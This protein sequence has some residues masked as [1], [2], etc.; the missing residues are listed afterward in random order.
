MPGIGPLQS[1]APLVNLADCFPDLQELKRDFDVIYFLDLCTGIEAA[2]LYD[3]VYAVRS[4]R[5]PGAD[6]LIDPLVQEG[7]IKLLVASSADPWETTKQIFAR[8]RIM[9]LEAKLRRRAWLDHDDMDLAMIAQTAASGLAMELALEEDFDCNL[10]LSPRQ[11]PVY[12]TLEPIERDEKVIADIEDQLADK[13]KKVRDSLMAVRR[14]TAYHALERIPLPPIAFEALR[15]ANTF[16]ELAARIIDLRK[17]YAR[18][19]RKLRQLREVMADRDE[20]VTNRLRWFHAIRADIVRTQDY[21][22]PESAPTLI[23]IA[24][25]AEK[26]IEGVGSAYAGDPLKAAKAAGPLLKI[27]DSLAWRLRMRPLLIT[28]RNYMNSSVQAF[29]E[30]TRILFR[31]DLNEVDCCRAEAYARAVAKYVDSPR[32]SSAPQPR[33]AS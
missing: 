20:S 30:T 27:V 14:D 12:L 9:E 2:V 21:P 28:S 11:V 31:H 33:L 10:V 25:D 26:I 15:L 1:G 24:E 32:I 22:K 7:A 4:T 29:A 19:R 6:P 18:L 23:E 17:R 13:Y 5:G 3:E 16:D 8:P